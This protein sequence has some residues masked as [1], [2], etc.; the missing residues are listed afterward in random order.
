[1]LVTRGMEKRDRLGELLEERGAHVVRVP[2]IET[3]K[4]G[5]ARELGPAVDRLRRGT[6]PAWLV[7]TSET[8][9]AILWDEIGERSA[10]AGIRVAAVGPATSAALRAG[11]VTATLVAAGQTAEAL[12]EELAVRRVAGAAVLVVAARGGRE[13]IAPRLRAAG[14]TVTVVEAYRSVLPVGAADRLRGALARTPPDAVTFTSG[15]TAA[16]FAGALGGL[17][18][19]ACPAICIGPVTAA[20]A[21]DAGFTTVVTAADHT[22]A[23]VAAATVR[24]LAAERL[25]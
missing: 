21:G 16:H 17:P 6:A 7:V 19:P 9:V 25:R 13:V 23:G 15:S 10:L 5:G 8:G 12:A 14:A 4:L 22:A 3:E 24:A 20:A 11:G 18:P 1:M 2:L